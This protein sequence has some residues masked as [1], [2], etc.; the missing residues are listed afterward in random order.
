MIA[1][2]DRMA[3]ITTCINVVKGLCCHHAYARQILQEEIWMPSSK[4]LNKYRI[5]PTKRGYE[6]LQNGDWLGTYATP[7]EAEAEKQH[8]EAFD[9]TLAPR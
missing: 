8:R 6:L 5:K 3:A 7:E 4:S 9:K 1:G 2:S